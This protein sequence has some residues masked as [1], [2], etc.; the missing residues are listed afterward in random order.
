MTD[1]VERAILRELGKKLEAEIGSGVAFA[2]FI[3]WRDSRPPSYLSNG[4]RRDVARALTEWIGKRSR[5]EPTLAV[6]RGAIPPLEA[7][8]AEVGKSM[9]EEDIDVTLFLF[10]MGDGGEV[11][12]FSTMPGGGRQL[13]EQFVQTVQQGGG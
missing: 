9:H 6:E 12:W 4:D 7:K 2:A 11:A 1:P 13:V 5:G 3:D 8:C 10:T